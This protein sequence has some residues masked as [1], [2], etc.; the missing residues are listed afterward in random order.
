MK[1]ISIR[2]NANNFATALEKLKV[3]LDK[4]GDKEITLA[5]AN[6]QYNLMEP[7]TLDAK[8]FPG[9]CRIRFIGSNVKKTVFSSCVQLPT[10][11]FKKVEGKPYYACQL[12]KQADGLYPL[13]RAFYANG[14]IAA[15]STTKAYQS[16]KSFTKEDGTKYEP[17]QEN[18]ND[19][20]ALYVP[21]DSVLEAGVE[22]CKGAELHLRVEWEF[23]IYHIDHIDMNDVHVDEDGQKHVMMY[24][25]KEETVHGNIALPVYDRQFFI[26]NTT[27]VLQNPGEYTY[28][29]SKGLIYYYPEKEISSYEFSLGVLTGLFTLNNFEHLTFSN[30]TFTGL[31][32]DILTKT[33]F[34]AA[35]QAGKWYQF[36]EMRPHAGVIRIHNINGLDLH[37]CIFTDLPCDGISMIGVLNNVSITHNHFTNLGATA[38]RIGR[39]DQWNE[40][41]Q[42]TN[43]DI[44]ENYLDN[45]GFTYENSCSIFVS[46]ARNA[47]V[48]HNTI[49]RS[50]YTG[51]SF[52]WKWNCADWGYGEYVNLENVEIAYNYV[53]SFLMNMCDGGGIYV[54]G[55]NTEV[56]AHSAFI[57]RIHDNVVI[58]D[59]LTCPQNGFFGSIYHDGASSNW[60][61]F[62][63]IVVHNKDR[64]NDFNNSAR[65]YL[66]NAWFDQDG[67][68]STA[69]QASWHILSENN[70]VCGCKKLGEVYRSM[71]DLENASNMLDVTRDN[72]EKDTHMLRSVKELKKYPEALQIMNFSGCNDVKIKKIL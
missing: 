41:N 22:N 3:Q 46:K 58:E 39:V 13:P 72:H 42:I 43:L 55:G 47:R 56:H 62:N 44:C 66:Q 27:S 18:W 14:K 71:T 29:R 8:D 40:D 1:C 28:E 57:N 4:P 10:E 54:L 15:V 70:Y 5:L 51:I 30:I 65:I 37:D 7:L 23:K 33:G 11:N 26:C 59:E 60:H 36:P 25:N 31:E 38:I 64:Y 53:K 49:L 67:T 45:I 19:T 32:D 61:T 35:D 34:Y 50:S 69:N 9:K 21:I 48:L 17:T 52:G 63:N 12:E 24:I 16:C 68:G 20:H 6:G 2:A